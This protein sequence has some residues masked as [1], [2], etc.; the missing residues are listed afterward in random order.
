MMRE[1]LHAGPYSFIARAVL[2]DVLA[3][4]LMVLAL[5]LPVK[6]FILGSGPPKLH[7]RTNNTIAG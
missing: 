7:P 4:V 6:T 1:S 5:V 2:K 3:F